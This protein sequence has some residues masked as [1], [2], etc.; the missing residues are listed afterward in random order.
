MGAVE[1]VVSEESALE[2]AKKQVSGLQSCREQ[3]ERS[4]K[5]NSELTMRVR[6]LESAHAE[7]S[8]LIFTCGFSMCGSWGF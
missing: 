4:E 3:A 7:K 8:I 6:T 2:S 1:D 5:A